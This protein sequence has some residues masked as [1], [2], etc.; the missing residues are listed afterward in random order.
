MGDLAVAGIGVFPIEFYAPPGRKGR[1]E[2][3]V[4]FA[5]R[6]GN[7]SAVSDRDYMDWVRSL[8]PAGFVFRTVAELTTENEKAFLAAVE[9]LDRDKGVPTGRVLE[10][11]YAKPDGTTE[12]IRHAEVV[13]TDAVSYDPPPV[14]GETVAK[15]TVLRATETVALQPGN[16]FEIPPGT[17]IRS[18]DTA[19]PEPERDDWGLRCQAA[20]ELAARRGCCVDISHLDDARHPLSDGDIGDPQYVVVTERATGRLVGLVEAWQDEDGDPLVPRTWL[21]IV[22]SAWD[23]A[24]DPQRA[25]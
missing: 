3:R 23:A 9:A 6:T 17:E 24:R 20:N 7:W 1:A 4:E 22:L 12:T 21:E 25:A 8:V 13:R 18:A 10:V 14:F 11:V 16:V 15:S 19:A 5:R 2:D